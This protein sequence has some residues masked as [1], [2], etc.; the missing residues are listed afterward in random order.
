MTCLLGETKDS[1]TELPSWR[2]GACVLSAT[3]P[4][5][6]WPAHIN[7][8]CSLPC[9]TVFTHNTQTQGTVQCLVDKEAAPD[10]Y[11]M[12]PDDMISVGPFEGTGLD[13]RSSGVLGVFR[14]VAVVFGR[15]LRLWEQLLCCTRSGLVEDCR[16][17]KWCEIGNSCRPAKF[18]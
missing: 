11:N 13:V 7:I 6:T 1:E 8:T 10:V 14:W 5:N 12:R 9:H 16:L 2:H 15:D 4:Q 17:S 3:R 18:E